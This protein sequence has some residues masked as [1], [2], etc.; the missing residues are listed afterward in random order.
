MTSLLAF[1]GCLLGANKYM[2][3]VVYMSHTVVVSSEEYAKMSP[4]QKAN[5]ITYEQREA[6]IALD[7]KKEA[8]ASKREKRSPYKKWA[9]VN[10]DPNICKARRQLIRDCPSAMVILEFLMEQANKKNAIMCSQAVLS[11]VLGY[12][13]CTVSRSLKVL[14]E[15]R[16]VGTAKCGNAKVYLLNRQVTWKAW[17]TS[18]GKSDCEY[19][20]VDTMVL[21]SKSEQDKEELE[22]PI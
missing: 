8:E 17:G 19:E 4:K 3:G 10:L 16:F 21:M 20:K 2:K 11:E 5:A 15:R 12:D 1:F 13:K 14:T 22:K 7:E 6:D 18:W 9:Q